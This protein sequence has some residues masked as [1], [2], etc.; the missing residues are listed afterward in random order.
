MRY[1]AAPLALVFVLM[2]CHSTVSSTT[3]GSG[4][5]GSSGSG[6]A[7]VTGSGGSGGG[8]SGGGAGL[9]G[10]SAGGT[11][12]AFACKEMD[13]AYFI[14][15]SGDGA[16]KHLSSGCTEP[17]PWAYFFEAPAGGGGLDVHGCIAGVPIELELNAGLMHVG[18]DN[19]VV[20]HYADANGD[21]WYTSQSGT[22][23]ITTYG[24]AGD[25][26]DGSFA[27]DVIKGGMGDDAG[28]AP[29]SLSGS[30]HVC[31]RPDVFAP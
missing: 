12:G 24:A 10:F 25:S 31:H 27:V 8:G 22:M 28:G 16:M 18:N 26:I 6:G 2:A 5:T 13:A 21:D 1:A 23:T 29:L 9:G 14:D 19:T 4:S 20:A 17:M 3:S 30:F 7:S 15:M 11:G